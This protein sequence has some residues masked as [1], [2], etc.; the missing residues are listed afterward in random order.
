MSFQKNVEETMETYLAVIDK[1]IARLCASSSAGT[2]LRPDLVE[3]VKR[4]WTAAMKARLHQMCSGT[5]DSDPRSVVKRVE[6][7]TRPDLVITEEQLSDDE[8]QDEFDSTDFH[9]STDLGKKKALDAIRAEEA[10]KVRETEKR[11]RLENLEIRKEQELAALEFETLD[12]SLADENPYLEPEACPLRLFA[13]PEVC[14]STGKRHD[15]KWLIVLLNGILRLEGKAEIL[16][17]SAR[18]TFQHSQS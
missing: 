11:R 16:F 17:R 3:A 2:K 8:F 1:S 10:E 4:K 15:S 18:Q 14:D 5:R 7:T 12:D 13:Q 9:H 6:Y